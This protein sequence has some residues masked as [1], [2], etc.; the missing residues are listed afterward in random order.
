MEE[1]TA[2]EEGPTPTTLRA[3]GNGYYSDDATKRYSER[4]IS[5]VNERERETNAHAMERVRR[6]GFVRYPLFTWNVF[7]EPVEA[8]AWVHPSFETSASVGFEE[9]YG[10]KFNIY[11]PS[12]ERAGSAGTMK[13]LDEFGI[14]NYYVCIDASQFEAYAKVYPVERL[15]VRDL[16]FR[17]PDML[18]AASGAAHP[19]TMAGHAP[20]CNFTLALSRSMGETHFWFHDD[21]IRKMAVKAVKREHAKEI[22]KYDA[23]KFYRVSHLKQSHGFDLRAFMA[24][25]EDVAVRVRNPGFVGLEKF[26]MTFTDPVRAKRGTRVFTYYLTSVETQIAHY[27]RQNNDIVTSL[28]LEKYGLVNLL[29]KGV[30]YDS[31]PTQGGGGQTDMYERWGTLDKTR[32]A[33]RAHPSRVTVMEKNNRIHHDTD[34][35]GLPKRVVGKPVGDEKE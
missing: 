7:G 19:I 10:M 32:V 34:F 17:D 26:G 5:E 25:I 28:E 15:V 24:E 20:L 21:D 13:V 9:R 18:N 31:E 11:I 29:F 4:E 1:T 27:G 35:R 12:F 22:K 30:A 14:G 3:L 16:R 2:V 33:V 8:E 6:E 23:R